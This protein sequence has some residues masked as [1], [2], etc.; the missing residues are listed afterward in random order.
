[1]ILTPADS[2]P[3]KTLS[4]CCAWSACTPLCFLPPCL[5]PS[6]VADG[7]VKPAPFGNG[8]GE[9]PDARPVDEEARDLSEKTQSDDAAPRRQRDNVFEG[10]KSALRCGAAA[11]LCNFLPL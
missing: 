3:S 7:G 2:C 11:F 4:V 8:D 1:M 9:N 5:P 6:S 10:D